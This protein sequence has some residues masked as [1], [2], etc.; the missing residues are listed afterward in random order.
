MLQNPGGDSC[1]L[2]ALLHF[3]ED[4]TSCSEAHV[5][6]QANGSKKTE[7]QFWADFL[8]SHLRLGR[9]EMIQTKDEVFDDWY[10]A[11]TSTEP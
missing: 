10:A 6:W 2:A 11:G 8:F 9:F 7:L 4:F 1:I 5:A 3:P